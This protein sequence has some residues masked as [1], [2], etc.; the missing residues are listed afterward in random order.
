MVPAV[1]R[2][3]APGRPD[4][5]RYDR[6]V[7][8]RRGPERRVIPHSEIQPEPDDDGRG[9]HRRLPLPSRHRRG[10]LDSYGR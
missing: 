9:F 6:P 7:A 3:K 10:G 1:L 4:E 8:L 5:Q 2:S